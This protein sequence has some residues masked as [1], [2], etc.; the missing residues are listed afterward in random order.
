MTGTALDVTVSNQ[1]PGDALIYSDT[2]AASR[3]ISGTAQV[4]CTTSSWVGGDGHRQMELTE[5]T[6]PK[7]SVNNVCFLLRNVK[8]LL[9]LGWI[10][11]V[12]TLL[13]I[14]PEGVLKRFRG[15]QQNRQ[16]AD[17]H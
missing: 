1:A 12:Q 14:F 6:G 15:L 5:N 10:P 9:L 16:M 2:T 13:V 11:S 17:L 3:A 8:Q 7:E 4:K